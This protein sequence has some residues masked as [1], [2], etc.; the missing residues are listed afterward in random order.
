MGTSDDAGVSNIFVKALEDK[1]PYTNKYQLI[2]L[3]F[4]LVNLTDKYR[5]VS[6]DLNIQVGYT[7]NHLVDSNVEPCFGFKKC[8]RYFDGNQLVHLAQH[9]DDCRIPDRQNTIL[10]MPLWSHH[11]Q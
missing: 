9:C 7:H 3:L 8:K 5:L 4:K 6:D 2:C 10:G 11:E 1:G